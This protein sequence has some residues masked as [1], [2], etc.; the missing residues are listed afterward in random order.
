MHTEN[1]WFAQFLVKFAGCQK[2]SLEDNLDETD[3]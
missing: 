2:Y 3:K 1:D